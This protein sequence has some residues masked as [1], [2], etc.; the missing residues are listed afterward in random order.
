MLIF[1][2]ITV[3]CGAQNEVS[4]ESL[5]VTDDCGVTLQFPTN[6]KRIAAIS[7]TAAD[8]AL[9]LGIMP[10]AVTYMKRGVDPDYLLGLT[11]HMKKVGQRAKPNMELLAE[12]KPDV[13]IAIK[14]YTKANAAKFQKIAPYIAYKM[15]V[16]D[17]SLNEVIELSRFFG[18]P[19]RG[20]KLNADFERNLKKYMAKVPKGKHPRFQ[21]MWPGYQPFS[22]CTE[23]TPS[24]IVSKLGGSNI[25]G[26]ANEGYFGL[27]ISLE[28][29]L[30]K[31]PEVIF[32]ID[33]GKD[34]PHESNPIW[35]KLSAVKNGRVYSVGDEWVETNGPIARE[36]VLRQAAH[37][38]YP[39]VF[40]DVDVKAL[41]KKMIPA[42]LQRKAAS[43]PVW[44][45]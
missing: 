13:I 33:Y 31:D 28:I 36:V 24:W 8:I 35:K 3:P 40:P 15:E 20:E 30:A 22:F 39:D 38:L 27:E 2:I 6:P 23:A 41:A 4:A 5:M 12:A 21:I 43:M 42:D 18:N 25:V 45:R 34:L 14:R 17:E 7:Y 10:V 9:A 44:M 37:Y 32:V 29:M 11:K 16:Y 19:K 26:S 1:S